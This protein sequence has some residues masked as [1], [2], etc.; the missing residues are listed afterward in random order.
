MIFGQQANVT[1][2]VTYIERFTLN[3]TQMTTPVVGYPVLVNDMKA[4]LWARTASRT[5]LAL[6]W[7]DGFLPADYAG[8]AFDYNSRGAVLNALGSLRTAAHELGHCMGLFHCWDPRSESAQTKIA[9]TEYK[10]LMGYGAGKF[11]R[12]KEIV[13]INNW[14]LPPN[15]LGGN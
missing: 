10:R 14:A 3:L 15:P 8:W 6:F 9:D 11:L 4:A 12:S 2:T 1:F 13:K 7:V 5:D